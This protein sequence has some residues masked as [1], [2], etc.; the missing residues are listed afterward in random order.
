MPDRPLFKLF[1]VT[2]ILLF[3][4]LGFQ[5]TSGCFS[6]RMSQK[7]FDKYFRDEKLKPQLQSYSTNGH[8][9]NYAITGYDS[10][11]TA[12]FFHG[13]PG[14]WSSF[15]HFLK[16]EDLLR[17]V[18]MISVDR[19]GYGHSDFGTSVVSLKEQAALLKPLL[20]QQSNHPVILIGH[21]LG[22]PLIARLAIDYP[23]LCDALIM[24]A[25]SIDPSLE[26]NE[27]W[28]RYPLRTPFLSWILPTSLRVTNDEIY[29]L[30]YELEQLKPHW[31]TITQPVTVIHGMDD[32]LVP[33]ANARFAESM[34]TN[35]S[36]E[37]ILKDDM[38]HFVPWNNPE[39]IKTAII[40]CA[41]HRD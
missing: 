6:F 1:R 8:K 20:Q 32:N 34:L 27:D 3:V 40:K 26:P 15:K 39:L 23:D 9:I 18:R 36:V 12:I 41:K 14:S 11:P 13:A 17:H 29:F 33:V 10:L 21:S 30:E 37:V 38:N 31:H 7:D 28:F 24:V 5:L 22:G 19:P 2:G 16:D 35:A 25:P 4:V